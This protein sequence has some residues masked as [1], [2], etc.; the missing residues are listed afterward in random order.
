MDAFYVGLVLI[1][2]GWLVQLYY[3]FR[4]RK[5]VQPLFVGV[6]LVGVAL[7]VYAALATGDTMAAAFQ[8]GSLVAAALVL[9]KLLVGK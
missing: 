7:L 3:L 8:G 4:G 2:I 9:G 1:I 5:E 6:Y